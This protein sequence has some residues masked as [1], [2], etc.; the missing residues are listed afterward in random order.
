MSEAVCPA[1]SEYTKKSAKPG[2]NARSTHHHHYYEHK[3]NEH[4][5]HKHFLTSKTNPHCTK[6]FK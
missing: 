4:V 5:S 6:E 3:P 2:V 1:R